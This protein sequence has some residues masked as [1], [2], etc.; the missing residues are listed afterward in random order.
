MKLL[1][2]AK[3]NAGLISVLGGVAV[4]AASW[5]GLEKVG[6]LIGVPAAAY[7]GKETAEA[8]EDKFERYLEKQEAYADALNSYVQQQ[9]QL[10][11]QQAPSIQYFQE[12]DQ[13]GQCWS[14]NAYSQ[15]QCWDN[16]L[17]RLCQ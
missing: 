4:L 3:D 8:V 15:Q 1:Q 13:Q 11:M 5:G 9:Q 7:E 14:C 12:Y 6:W 17:W 10:P 2:Q 16:R